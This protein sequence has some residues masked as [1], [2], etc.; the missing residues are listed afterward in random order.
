M[1]VRKMKPT[2]PGQRKMVR[3][4]NPGLHKGGPHR[5]LTEPKKR[6]SGRNNKGRITVRHRGG[7]H[8]RLYRVIDFR[9]ADRDGI[10]AKVERIEYDPNRS[11]HILLLCYRDGA[12]RYIIAP[13]GVS[14][15][16]EI[17]S[18]SS[19]PV[20][21][22]NC[23][24]LA[25]IPVGTTVHCV[26]MRPGK[27]AQ[28]ARSAGSYAQLVAVEPEHALLRM[29]SGEVRKVPLGCR[30]SVGAVG[31]SEHFLRKLGKA[32]AKVHRGW[33]PTVRGMAMNPVDHPMGGGEGRSKSNKIPKSPWG[34]PSKGYRTRNNPRTQ[35]MIVRRRKK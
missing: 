3:V 4:S 19:A 18:G 8:K 6:I 27:G 7:G 31:N 9:R 5:P 24:P 29:K 35:K 21:R 13:E 16:D 15:G 1:P 20:K 28:L 33:R 23:L 30:A 34:T 2:T 25:N 17:L 12:R 11:A 22:G 14:V 26:E 32:G 10:P